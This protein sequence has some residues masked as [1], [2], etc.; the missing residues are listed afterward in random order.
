LSGIAFAVDT[1][2]NI[3]DDIVL[4]PKTSAFAPGT[5]VTPFVL[6]GYYEPPSTRLSAAIATTAPIAGTMRRP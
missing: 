2:F 3:F 6:T 1:N 4:L 5:A